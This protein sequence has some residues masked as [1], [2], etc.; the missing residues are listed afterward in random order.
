MEERRPRSNLPRPLTAEEVIDGGP[1]EPT[2]TL[3]TGVKALFRDGS[4][5][6]LTEEQRADGSTFWTLPGGG[7]E[8]R[9]SLREGLRRELREELRCVAHIS[10]EVGRCRYRHTS[11]PTVVTH[12][13]VFSGTLLT[14]PDANPEEGVLNYEWVDPDDPPAGTLDPF[15]RIVQG[16]EGSRKAR[17]HIPGPFG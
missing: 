4:D 3:R 11:R 14:R 15:R 6:L 5:V 7:V 2:Y 9:E 10:D 1:T 17:S 12:Y 8:P 13:T 16:C